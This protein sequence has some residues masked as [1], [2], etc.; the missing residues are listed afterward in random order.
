MI[1][2]DKCILPLVDNRSHQY[3]VPVSERTSKCARACVYV[4]SVVRMLW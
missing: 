2:T 4:H 3:L 1:D